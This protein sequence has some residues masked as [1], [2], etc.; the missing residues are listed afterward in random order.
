MY[1][2]NKIGL[3]ES[4]AKKQ[5]LSQDDFDKLHSLYESYYELKTVLDGKIDDSMIDRYVNIVKE[6]ESK[7]Q[8]SWN[9]PHNPNYHYFT[10]TLDK[11][12]CPK[13]DNYERRG[14]AEKVYNTNCRIHNTMVQCDDEI[15]F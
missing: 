3:N 4:L 2:N 11:C 9:F 14:V 10:F 5:G 13:L 1:K 7:I 8:I 6:L 15:A 12:C